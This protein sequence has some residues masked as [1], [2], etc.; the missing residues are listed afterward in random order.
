VRFVWRAARVLSFG[1]VAYFWLSVLVLAA[2]LVWPAGKLIWVLS[3]RR[4]QRRQRRELSTE[5]V[6]GQRGRAYFIAV[7]VCFIFSLL[8]NY[9]LLR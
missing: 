4:L 8:F 5:E 2:L 9:S 3:V 6:E 7:L 1:D